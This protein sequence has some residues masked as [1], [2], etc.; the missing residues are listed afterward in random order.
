MKAPHR[1]LPSLLLVSLLMTVAANPY[2]K[3]CLYSKNLTGRVRVCGS[4]D[5]PDAVASGL[6][7]MPAMDYPEIRLVPG[8]WESCFFE[9]WILQILLSEILRIPT[10]IEMGNSEG[11][12][13]LYHP[14]SPMDYPTDYSLHDTAFVNAFEA[15][16]QC[17]KVVAANANRPEE[18]YQQ[19][20]HFSPETWSGL[21]ADFQ[22]LVYRGKLDPIQGLGM[23]GS[24]GWFIPKFTAQRDPTLLTYLG[25]QGEQNRQKLAETF[26]RP[27]TWKD[28]CTLVSKD[29]CTTPDETAQR[30]PES[31]EEHNHMFVADLYTGH[32]R[33]TDKN[34]CTANPTTCSGHFIDYPCDWRSPVPGQLHYLNISLETDWEDGGLYTYTQLTQIWRAANATK[35]N[36]IYLWWTPDIMVGSFLESDAEFTSVSLPPPKQACLDAQ[37]SMNHHCSPDM[38]LRIGEPEMVCGEPAKSLHSLLSTTVYQSYIAGEQ[39]PLALQSPAYTALSNF[40]FSELQLGEVYSLWNERGD[41]RESICEWVSHNMDFVQ[42]FVPRTYPRIPVQQD[43]KGPLLYASV[44]LGAIVTGMI[45][46]TLIM[47]GR[48]KTKPAIQTAQIE[49]LQL[50]L[51]G[52][53][54]ISLGSIVIGAP[55]TTASCITEIWLVNVGYTLALVPLIVKVA[56]VNHVIGMGRKM[57]RVRI[58]RDFLFWSVVVISILA[59]I[60]VAIWTALDPPQAEPE[61]ELSDSV[62]EEGNTIVWTVAVCKS[63]SAVWSYAAVSWNAFLLFCASIEAIKMRKVEV[64]GFCETPTLALLVYSNAFFVLLRVITYMLSSQVSEFTLAR[65][66][67]LIYS[68]DTAATIVIYFVPKFLAQDQRHGLGTSKES[69]YMSGFDS[70]RAFS[71][72]FSSFPSKGTLV[73]PSPLAADDKD[74]YNIIMAA[75][76][77]YKKECGIPSG[78]PCSQAADG[79]PANT[80][81]S[82]IQNSFTDGSTS[83]PNYRSSVRRSINN[84]RTSKNVGSTR[85]F[86]NSTGQ[87]VSALL[88]SSLSTMAFDVEGDDNSTSNA[89]QQAGD[90]APKVVRSEASN[91]DGENDLEHAG[92]APGDE[93]DESITRALLLE[94]RVEDLTRENQCQLKE[95]QGIRQ[96]L[97]SKEDEISSLKEQLAS[98]KRLDATN[99]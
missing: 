96:E 52:A 87:R 75:A 43:P 58:K 8:N 42:S 56:G 30:A 97:T 6:C 35:S 3:G 13:S 46:C 62:T 72:K 92:S 98:D 74:D 2:Q 17:D 4:E 89:E 14:D 33:A 37:P 91:Y 18:D 63:E 45:L 49:F 81:D 7:E 65:C 95:L 28:Y 99:T 60:Y 24:Q 34:N 67:S 9:T 1:N 10:S 78:V 70:T 71:G 69:T 82:T 19:C 51:L 12:L 21:K 26:L 20:G 31:P 39:A 90:H 76:E 22:D 64:E 68:A 36:V 32:F 83:N 86:R 61:Y 25:M 5:G 66:R 93:E 40:R 23:I 16:G 77:D 54:F 29:N 57:Q 85:S 94:K 47:V 44:I 73:N 48:H 50:L 55:A 41:A 79:N 27:T 15:N 88:R 84:L 38:N 59:A 80:P 11:A 53:L